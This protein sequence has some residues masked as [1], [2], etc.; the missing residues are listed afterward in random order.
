M[1]SARIPWWV[2]FVAASFIAC[3]V[4]G[5]FYL[6]FKLPQAT[7]INLSFPDNR[8]ASVT[9]GSP[10][11]AAGFKRD[12]RIVNVDGRPIRN[13]ID[14][15]S[16]QSNT[17][18]DHPVSIVVL[19][20]GQEVRLQLSLNQSVTQAWTSKEYVGW[21]V[22][23]AVSLIQ[24][25]VG[26]LVLFKR[27]RDLT[28]V[29]A[30]IFLCSLGTGNFYFTAPNAAVVWRALPLAIQWLIFPALIL[31]INGLPVAPLLLFSLSFP[32]PLLHRRWAWIMLA[33]LAMPLVGATA[34][35]NYIVLFAPDRSVGAF[36]HWQAAFMELDAMFTFLAPILILAANYFRLRDVNERRR[37]RLVVV[38]LLLFFGDLIASGLLS[39]SQKTLW[40]STAAFSPLVFGLVQV[41]FTICVAYAVLKQRLFQVSFIV[42]Q[43][44]QYAVAR[45]ALL[46]PIPVL[47]GIL[48]FDLI[49]H[50]DQPLGV[51]LSAHGWAY[52]LMVAAGV[53]AHKK[54]KQWMEVLDRHFYREHYNAQ[55][56]LRQTVDEI[57]NSSNL[58]EV[59]PKA[60]GRIE[61][62]LHPEFVA[63]LMREASEPLYR[64]IAS[65]PPEIYPRGLSPD[66]KLMSAFRLFAKP[67]QISLAE[68]GWLKQQLPSE[69]TNFLR[70]ARIDLMVPIAIAPHSRE[71]LMVLGPK[72][73]EEPYGSEDQELL[74]GI[75]SALA[76][77]LERPVTSALGGFE[78]C[79]R[80]GLCYESGMGHCAGEGAQ[81]TRMPFKRLLTS[82]YRLEQK[83]G[84]GGMGTVY[85]A[86]DTSLERAVAVKLIREDLVA[87]SEA[88][89]RFRREAKAAAS[90]AHPNLVIVHDFGVDSDTRVFLVMELLQG[91]TLRQRFEQQKKLATQQIL[92]ILGGVCAGLQAAHENGLIHRDLKP[93]NIFLTQ[94]GEGEVA[95]ILDFGL[96]KFLVSPIN[97]TAATVDTLPGVLMGT[98]QYMSP[99]QLNGEAASAAWDI[100]ALG[101]ITY[102]MLTGSHPFPATSVGQMHHSIVS[103]RFTPLSTLLPDAPAEWQQFF[104]RAL[105]PKT[106][107]RPQSAKEFVSALTT[108]F[109]FSEKST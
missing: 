89:D 75:G 80:C 16:A 14:A 98:P 91:F 78:E 6:P 52:A 36:P 65:A 108:A 81:L 12:D 20:A 42:R 57:R 49:V 43:S 40:L 94:S 82:R 55:H 23:V 66:S 5:F 11:D 68:S 35:F 83:L 95:K 105:N 90:F 64:C 103:G 39:L 30:G 96:A 17:T 46:I 8:V 106:A 101:V 54:Q 47:A 31:G 27:P 63:I 37:I 60:V 19:R 100:W 34:I 32:K 53:V 77:L 87:S 48:I 51:L 3:F 56:L 93:E 104:E 50:K 70:D 38:G 72:K 92:R 2:W 25:L 29:A 1:P 9:P 4:V 107:V 59:A 71:A 97:S 45:G 79:P 61:Q 69:D 28:A 84:R 18:F 62:A 109:T 44:L 85:K 102:E 33:V 10:G 26:L 74:S 7:G 15:V 88:A 21:W 58:A 24:L 22:E 73:S 41:P 13:I 67:L 76:L 99:D 86:T